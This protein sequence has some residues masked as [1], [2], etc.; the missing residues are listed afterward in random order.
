MII[1]S[2]LPASQ[3]F[4]YPWQRHMSS[5]AP[6]APCVVCLR[7]VEPYMEAYCGVCG[8][9]YHLNSR[10]DLP[11]ED[12]GQ[13]WINEEHLG[14]EFGCNSCLN[15]PA[16]PPPGGALDDILDLAE[17]ATAG[18][19]AEAVLERAAQLGHIKHRRTGSGVLLFERRDVLAFAV[20]H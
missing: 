19:I 9:L 1:G 14:L 8:N 12:C 4:L 10:A 17:A 15:P 6:S 11:G 5:E 7:S 20:S 16:D 13:V 3:G 18:G 2:G